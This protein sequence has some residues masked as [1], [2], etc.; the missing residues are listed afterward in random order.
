[1]IDRDTRWP[2]V[3]T[4]GHIDMRPTQL[5]QA[6]RPEMWSREAMR[7]AYPI[8]VR[9]FQNFSGTK[10]PCPGGSGGGDVYQMVLY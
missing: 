8:D 1:M 6:L 5:A 9:R 10:R 7:A 4:I 2:N 3:G